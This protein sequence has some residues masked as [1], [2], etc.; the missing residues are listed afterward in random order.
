MSLNLTNRHTCILKYIYVL[1]DT[2]FIHLTQCRLQ[3]LQNTF[4]LV[5]PILV[6]KIMKDVCE[7]SNLEKDL[8]KEIMT[9]M[10]M[11][12]IACANF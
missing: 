5:D 1:I 8:F 6:L 12:K 3:P 4:K 2:I 10:S 7:F 9:F 11:I